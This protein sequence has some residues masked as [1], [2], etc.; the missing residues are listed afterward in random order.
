MTGRS[1][2]T[3]LVPELVAGWADTTPDA[4]AAVDG[5]RTMT[6][7]HL[8]DR[9]HGVAGAL[10]ASGAGRDEVIGL[11]CAR[12]LPGLIGMLGI[13]LAGSA[14]LYLDPTWPEPRRRQMVDQCRVRTVLT[15]S[16]IPSTAR[17]AR[18]RRH[19]EP[20]DLCYVVYTSGSTGG[21][22]GV[23]VEHGGVANMA[24]ELAR[25]F[26]LQRGTRVLQFANWAWDA[27]AGEILPALAAGG[28]VVVAGD[29]VRHGGE[30]LATLLRRHRVQVAT[31][32]PS[33][34][35]ALPEADLP[36]LRTVV[37]VGEPC[38]AELVGRWARG[39]RFLNGYGPTE[40]TVA[41]S[42]GRCGPGE[43]V[44]I[45]QPLPGVRVRVLDSQGQPVVPGEPGELVVGGAGVARGYVRD[46]GPDGHL[47]IEPFPHDGDTRW[48]HTGDLVSQRPD[49]QLVHH[50]RLDDQVK[51]RGHR[52][53]LA[54]V[55][56][57]LR[58]HPGVRACAAIT[59]GG[60][61]VAHVVATPG[62]SVGQ[63]LAAAAGWLPDFMVPD[64]V[65]LVDALPLN[66]NGKLDRRALAA[67]P[68]R[69]R[70]RVDGLLAEVLD[71]VR[72]AL[73]LDGIGPHDDLF[74][75]GG[76]SLVAAQLAVA[77]TERFGVPVTALHVYDHP[78][79]ARLAEL[80][81]TLAGADRKAA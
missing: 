9:A 29:T 38:P 66:A 44:T 5:P 75:A 15:D 77:A 58:Q 1:L 37:A 39:R 36:D 11:S 18:Q 12:G 55:E 20:G 34:L 42:V 13:L 41:V 69:V 50:G 68:P 40:A 60:R 14:Y 54:E 21:P 2:T 17:P 52:V 25:V 10:R 7:R 31:L 62:V 23:A 49:G 81:G 48:Y 63:V 65:R 53:E 67:A 74:D 45:G 28:T 19:T 76:H 16:A 51:V 56:H 46:P 79:A 33:L 35:S 47:V 71:L 26:G 3:A 70:S 24:R 8:V 32:T 4:V 59:T 61:L 57:G 64:E 6:Y 72:H 30:P 27:A 78:S 80:I 43:P 73:E 22:R